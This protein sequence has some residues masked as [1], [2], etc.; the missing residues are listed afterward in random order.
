MSTRAF[1]C[2]ALGLSTVTGCVKVLG[3][4]FEDLKLATGG[5]AGQ[6]GSA[7]GA[8]GVGQGGSS[9]AG[10]GDENDAS[11][12]SDVQVLRDAPPIDPDAL[13]NVFVI[14]EMEGVG[15]DWIELYNAGSD[16][17]VLDG[18][19]VAQASGVSG[20]PDVGNAL[21][22]PAGTSLNPGGYVLVVGK[23]L[24]TGPTTSC[25]NLAPSCYSVL[26]GI[27]SSSGEGMYILLPDS[28]PLSFVLYPPPTNDGGAPV[29]GQTW[30][31]MPNGTGNFVITVPTPISDNHQ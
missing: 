21:V 3:A 24:T 16:T 19:G 29:S 30:G 18:F 22:F 20:P 6:G 7:A 5:A 14:N 23:G 28:T 17:L 4:D 1:F 15:N 26:W 10:G 27:S 13:V 8:G 25:F 9:G 11:D 31:R 2:A 12:V